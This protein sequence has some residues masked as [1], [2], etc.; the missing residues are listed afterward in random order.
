MISGVRQAISRRVRETLPGERG[1]IA[2]AL[3][4]GQCG[5]ISEATNNAYRDSGLYHI[6]L[7]SGLHMTIMAGAVFFAVRLLLA[8]VPAIALRFE[9]KKWAAVIA[10]LAALGY[11][12][13]SGAAFA[14]VRAWAMISIM[15][16]AV[17]PTGRR[18]RCATSR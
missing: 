17:S 10:T 15:F 3:I 2:D 5:G 7:I 1:A 8:A 11:L 12:L 6:L 4:T 18:S 14:T 16:L 13:I 9:I